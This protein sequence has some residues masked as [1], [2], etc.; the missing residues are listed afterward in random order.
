MNFIDQ[1]ALTVIQEID[2]RHME[3]LTRTLATIQADV[4][5][6]SDL[7][8][9]KLQNVH[10]CRFVIVPGFENSKGNKIPAQLAYSTNFDISLDNHITHICAPDV[11]Q[12]FVKIFSC[13]KGF[14]SSLPA[15]EA[16]ESFIR[17]YQRKVN[18]FYRGHRGLSVDLIRRERDIYKNI[19][20]FLNRNLMDGLT[21]RQIKNNIS[22]YVKS[23]TAW[24]AV[25][26]VKLSHLS[27][28]ALGVMFAGVVILGIVIA[29][30]FGVFLETAIPVVIVLLSVVSYL[31]FLEVNADQ[32]SETDENYV[33]VQDL[34][35]Q[36]DIL[37]QNQLTHLVELRAGRFRR[38][39]QRFGLWAIDLLA[40][41][42]YNKG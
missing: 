6:N 2:S 32:L 3:S 20:E 21:K 7:P 19:Q 9:S 15:K 14:D 16:L 38:V 24:N 10:F 1:K 4:E 36:E 25:L 18:T 23:V 39:L 40:T 17:K 41:Y 8:F 12:G 11:I 37:I 27:L 31:R 35:R 34:T 29:C 30:F 42:T 5:S 33:S 26:E 28:A 13:C 22:I